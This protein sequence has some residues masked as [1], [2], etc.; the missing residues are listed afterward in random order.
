MIDQG[1]LVYFMTLDKTRFRKLVEPGDVLELHVRILR[2]RGNEHHRRAFAI[3]LAFGA[4]TAWL[5]ALCEF[6]GRRWFR[7]T[8][9]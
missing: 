9:A 4:G 8:A 1:L 6:R 7:R 3:A 2:G 5:V